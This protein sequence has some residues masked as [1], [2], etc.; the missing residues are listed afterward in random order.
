M[1]ENHY[2]RTFFFVLLSVHKGFLY[3]QRTIVQ[4]LKEINNAQETAAQLAEEEKEVKKRV[5]SGKF[6]QKG[7]QELK[8]RQLKQKQQN[9]E[10]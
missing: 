3:F 9:V 7:I 6:R 2:A 10:V 1:A 4:Y 8:M 5:A